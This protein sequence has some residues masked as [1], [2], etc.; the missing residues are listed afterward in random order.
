MRNKDIIQNKVEK[1]ELLTKSLNFHIGRM[2]RREAYEV[3]DEIN[4][5]LSYM[6]TLLN[7]ETQ[8]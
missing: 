8:D 4:S 7:T 2:E 1:L 5:N 3:L 6:Q